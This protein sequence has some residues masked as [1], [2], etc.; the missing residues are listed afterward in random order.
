MSA[1]GTQ[2][3]WFGRQR[4]AALPLISDFDLLGHSERV[5]DLDPKIANRAFNLCVAE[6]KRH[7]AELTSSSLQGRR[8]FACW[9]RGYEQ[10]GLNFRCINTVGAIFNRS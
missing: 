8:G 9:L 1:H 10:R 4:M 3:T 2:R 7:G 5:V 6:Q